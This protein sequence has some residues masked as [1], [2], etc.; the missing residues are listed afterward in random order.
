MDLYRLAI[1]LNGRYNKDIE[2]KYC[3]NNKEKNFSVD[4][5]V[6]NIDILYSKDNEEFEKIS[7]EL[8][9]KLEDDFEKL[10]LEFKLSNINQA[11][12]FASHLEKIKCF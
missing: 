1:V 6:D 5:S 9:K 8:V 7:E 11:R 10:S 4:L 2:V 3:F 12:A